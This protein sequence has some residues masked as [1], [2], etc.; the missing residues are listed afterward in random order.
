MLLDPIVTALEIEGLAAAPGVLED[1]QVLV[2]ARIALVV[3]EK[4]AVAPLFGCVAA[5]DD[6]DCRASVAEMVEGGEL[7]RRYRRRD[8]AWPVRH[9]QAEAASFLGRLGSHLQAVRGRA[10]VSDQ[11]PVE[12]GVLLGTGTGA[13]KGLV[14]QRTVARPGLAGFPMGKKTDELDAMGGAHGGAPVGGG[15]RARL[16][17]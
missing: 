14:H 6:V 7:A 5:A 10:V 13:E 4:V 16:A 8:P 3:I 11:R 17:R 9:Q 15:G 2:G 12:A 1:V